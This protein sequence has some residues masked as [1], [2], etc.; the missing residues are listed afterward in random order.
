LAQNIIQQVMGCKLMTA[1]QRFFF[2]GQ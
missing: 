1:I 2:I